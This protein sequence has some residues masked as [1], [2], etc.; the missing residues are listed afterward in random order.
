MF[1]TANSLWERS[2]AECLADFKWLDK[3]VVSRGGRSTP[4]AIGSTPL[5]WPDGPVGIV[6]PFE[7]AVLVQKRLLGDLQ[8]LCS[9]ADK[10]GDSALADAIRSSFMRKETR[11]VKCLADLLQQVVQASKQPG[12]GLHLL[13]RKLRHTDGIVP[14][15]LFNELSQQQDDITKIKNI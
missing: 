15:D 8:R 1:L 3:Y 2:A 4:R 12:L 5:D 13:D 9:S 14:S 11:H 7:E 6:G 10:S